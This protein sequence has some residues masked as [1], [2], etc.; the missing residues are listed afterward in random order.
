MND[1]FKVGVTTIFKDVHG[2][3]LQSDVKATKLTPKGANQILHD[4]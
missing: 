3:Q 1:A 2:F 4:K